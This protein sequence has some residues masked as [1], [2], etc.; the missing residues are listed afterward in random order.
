MRVL[1][2]SFEYRKDDTP[3]SV[4]QR[5]AAWTR[6]AIQS[7]SRIPDVTYTAVT[8]PSGET[9]D[10]LVANGIPRSVLVARVV[11]GTVTAA[12]GIDWVPVAGGFTIRA[13]YGVAGTAVLALRVE[14]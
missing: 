9:V 1:P 5:V 13:V 8:V 10:V 6:D 12:P 11:S 4:G 2:R 7:F 3:E 14:V